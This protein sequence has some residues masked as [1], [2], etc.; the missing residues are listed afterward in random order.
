MARR[1][2]DIVERLRTGTK[3]DVYDIMCEA[4]DEIERLRKDLAKRDELMNAHSMDAFRE[5]ERLRK[6]ITME[7]AKPAEPEAS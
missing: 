5:I 1:M 7:P 6:E 4:A 3:D 2:T